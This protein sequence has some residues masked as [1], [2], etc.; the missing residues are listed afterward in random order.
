MDHMDLPAARGR[1]GRWTT[2][3]RQT[4]VLC[5]LSIV[6]AVHGVHAVHSARLAAAVREDSK[7]GDG[8]LGTRSP[9]LGL[10]DEKVERKH[11]EQLE[12]RE[13]R[14]SREGNRCPSALT[15]GRSD[16]AREKGGLRPKGTPKGVVP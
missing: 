2:W 4:A 14:G 1:H 15:H 13:G 9:V 6:H 16:E 5:L 12:D 3:T 10:T 8:S 7:S 11:D